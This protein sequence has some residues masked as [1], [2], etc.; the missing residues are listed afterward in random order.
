[1]EAHIQ[2]F[3]AR[4][5]ITSADQFDA[6]I[7]I[8]DHVP[9]EPSLVREL[10]QLLT[11]AKSFTNPKAENA[12]LRFVYAVERQ[13]FA[14]DGYTFFVGQLTQSLHQ[15]MLFSY[16]GCID[17]IR[18]WGHVEP[19]VAMQSQRSLLLKNQTL[20]SAIR[21]VDGVVPTP[22]Y[23]FARG[24]K[25]RSA[26]THLSRSEVLEAMECFAMA[27][28]K[29]DLLCFLEFDHGVVRLKSC[30]TSNEVVMAV[31]DV[32]DQSRYRINRV[33]LQR[34]ISA[35]H[36]ETIAFSKISGLRPNLSLEGNTSPHIALLSVLEELS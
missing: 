10:I 25:E 2:G 22:L 34:C 13:V 4:L 23:R 31:P 33:H 3:R 24:T 18:L 15:R 30:T 5:P 21:C 14:T 16:Q 17:L 28:N 8:I 35:I 7:K 19:I 26:K 6:D 29:S 11:T 1:V 32:T 20:T 9:I 36:G 12:A 27:S